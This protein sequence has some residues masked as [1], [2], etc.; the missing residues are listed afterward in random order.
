MCGIIGVISLQK[1][2]VKNTVMRLLLQ[3]QIRGKHATGISYLE[4]EKYLS[5]ISRP[6]SAKNFIDVISPLDLGHIVI[7]H[8]RYS[9][10][11]IEYNQPIQEG[12][13]SLVHN[14][15]I[16][17]A[18]F[19]QWESLY[20]YTN[21]TTRND[22]EI[23]LKAWQKDMF[24]E[25]EN[26]SIAAGMIANGELLCW[27]NERRPLYLFHT[28]RMCGFASTENIIRRALNVK[29]ILIHK[30]IPNTIYSF[31]IKDQELIIGSAIDKYNDGIKAKDLQYDT[32][33][34][35]RYLRNECIAT[36]TVI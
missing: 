29:D 1:A 31:S 35:Y 13:F 28:N 34:G 22:S 15:V 26:S 21:F 7:G 36:E 23:L 24:C 4:D 30:A 14:G 19:E 33:R 3:S 12:S 17:Q 10:S 6:T 9:T 27:R 32:V 2:L 11:D 16:T 8:T 18:P 25:F 5:T 20:G